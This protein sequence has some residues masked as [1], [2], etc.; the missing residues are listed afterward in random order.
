MTG[1]SMIVDVDSQRAVAERTAARTVPRH[2]DADQGPGPFASC[3]TYSF[4]PS[5]SSMRTNWLRSQ[6]ANQVFLLPGET[7]SRS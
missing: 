2:P 3:S 7:A 1:F 4:L 6:L 5:F